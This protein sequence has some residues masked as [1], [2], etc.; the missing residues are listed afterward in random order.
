MLFAF[1]EIADVLHE[2]VA[3]EVAFVSHEF[4][5]LCLE[6]GLDNIERCHQKRSDDGS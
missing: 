5:L 6:P 1:S 2:S 3:V 4:L